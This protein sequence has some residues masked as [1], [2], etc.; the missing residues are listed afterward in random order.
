M[1]HAIRPSRR[2]ALSS[3]ALALASRA[4][5]QTWPERPVR[6][7]V[8]FPASSTPDIAMRLLAGPIGEGLGQP[9]VV[10]NRTGASGLLA[11][12]ALIRAPADGHT[13]LIMP[14]GTLLQLAM[15][16]TP[17]FDAAELSP[18]A[19]A[20]RAPL[21][22]ITHPGL[23]VADMAGFV[24]LSR[25]RGEQFSIGTSGRVSAA[26]R[27]MALVGEAHGLT[28]STIAYRGDTD[29]ATAV[30]GRQIDAGFVFLGIA[31]EH[32]R[33]GRLRALAITSPDRISL[34][35]NVP[36]T[37]ELGM[38]AVDVGG[39]WAVTVP[40]ATPEHVQARIAQVVRTARGTALYQ[41]RLAGAGA[42]PLD[43]DGALLRAVYE[44]DRD[45]QVALLRR[46]GIDR[47]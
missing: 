41:D 3:G 24:A 6:A 47:E 13:I 18:I 11:A 1:I 17:P 8:G 19:G 21:V 31:M 20:A 16:R 27:A 38:P 25:A 29:I 44:R 4:Q 22:L 37:A 28:P 5:A 26:A 39:Y 23:E 35:P 12:E 9:I 7:L 30:L 36:T 42:L 14:I 34:L 46:L 32:V 43:V 15:M 33:A 40:R 2:L 10:E 45:Q